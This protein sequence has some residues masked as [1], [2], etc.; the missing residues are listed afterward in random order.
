MALNKPVVRA[1]YD[2]ADVDIGV[3]GR[4]TVLRRYFEVG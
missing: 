2:F 3:Q 4:A 1:C